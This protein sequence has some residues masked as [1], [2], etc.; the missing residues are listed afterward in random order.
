MY[1][2]YPD[3]KP[4]KPMDNLLGREDRRERESLNEKREERR[5]PPREEHKERHKEG[6]GL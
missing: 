5:E 1:G 3:Y 2:R 6:G 4:F